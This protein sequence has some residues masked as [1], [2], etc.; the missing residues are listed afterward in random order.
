MIEF[1]SVTPGD[2]EL[3]VAH[4]FGEERRD[5]NLSVA[6]LCGWQ[7]LT[8]SSYAIVEG[9]LVIRFCFRDNL[10]V[11]T[12]PEWG[13]RALP[14]ILRLA[15]QAR[16]ERLPLYLYGIVPD[17]QPLLEKYFPGLFEFRSD[18]D[19]FDYLYLREDLAHLRGKDFQAKRN[20]VNKFN[21]NYVC[22]YTPL[23]LEMIPACLSFYDE[24]C[25]QRHCKDDPGL[26]HEQQA[27]HFC[28]E[29][30]RELLLM[31]GVLWV[32]N[33]IIAF[34][35]GVAINH[36]TF[37]VHVE[38]AFTSYEGAYNVINQRLAY[39][40]PED[41]IYINREEDLGVPGLRKAKLSYRPV[42]ILEKGIAVCPSELLTGNK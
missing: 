24:W 15:A 25:E 1:K 18:R 16:E 29:N 26:A 35:Y 22:H 32:D 20:H 21:K 9:L 17:M 10:T 42:L 3:L 6:N 41:F 37:C 8:C 19:H 12:I 31:G 30:F 11:Y 36:D 5:S 2:R 7:F 34:T 33:R 39:S 27:V 23:L 40:L 38:K 28:L 4:I 13:E 14:V